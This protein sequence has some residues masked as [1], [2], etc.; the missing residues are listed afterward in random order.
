MPKTKTLD[1]NALYCECL[2]QK[3][4]E[5]KELKSLFEQFHKINN[6]WELAFWLAK[7]QRLYEEKVCQRG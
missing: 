2:E 4:S 1:A 5:L 3:L 6:Q 7:S